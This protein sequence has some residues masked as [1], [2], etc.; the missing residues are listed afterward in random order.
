[1]SQRL[2]TEHQELLVTAKDVA[3]LAEQRAVLAAMDRPVARLDMYVAQHHLAAMVR[4]SSTVALAGDGADELFG[5]Y[6]WF[7]EPRAVN[8][9]TF[10][11][12]GPSYRFEMFCGLLDRQLVKEL[13][14][15]SY[16]RDR[17]AE[18]LAEVPH[19]NGASAHERRMRELT[20]LHLTRYL[21][22]MVDR[23]DRMGASVALE[24]RVPFCDHHLVEYVFNVP[25]AMKSADGREKSLLRAAV[26]DL[27][28]ADIVG[29]RKSP[30]PILQDPAY[31]AA[32]REELR[33][34]VESTPDP[35]AGLLDPARLDAVLTDPLETPLGTP[36]GELPSGVNRLSIETAIMLDL[37]TRELGVTIAV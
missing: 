13:D 6:R 9:P 12:F 36:F 20:Y 16:I 25:W 2:G 22:V 11:W 4:K 30:F 10:P 14:L 28:P 18:A 37:W 29:R 17:Y 27:V 5:G 34:L 21:R 31:G 1:M 23:K 8:A 32:L 19:V 26:A 3:D 33:E 15:A 24:G 35:A 7:H